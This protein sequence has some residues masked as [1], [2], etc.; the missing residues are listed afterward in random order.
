MNGGIDQFIQ[1]L[2]TFA[3]MGF[4]IVQVSDFLKSSR[5]SGQD[6]EPYIFY[7][8]GRYTRNLIYKDAAFEIL[9]LCWDGF[10]LSPIHG[11]EGEKCW[12]RVEQ[13]QMRF[14]NFNDQN[15]QDGQITILSSQVGGPGFVD[16]P[17]GIHQVENIGAD[18][19][20]SLH[21]YARPF[22]ACDV[23]D[24]GTHRK[25]RKELFYDT[26]YGKPC[27]QRLEQK[28]RDKHL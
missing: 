21:L 17:A 22:A 8:P 1:Q 9:L 19:A 4:P 10:L 6:L 12:M 15:A 11:H 26:V 28:K 24:A 16:G 25:A 14:K 5:I 20:L 27:Q 7:L 3:Q 2:K 18:R 13:G 23:Y